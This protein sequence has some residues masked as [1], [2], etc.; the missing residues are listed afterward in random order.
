MRFS[1]DAESEWPDSKGLL[2]GFSCVGVGQVAVLAYY[3]LRRFGMH[4]K[5]IQIRSPPD[6]TLAADLWE[7]VASPESFLMVFGYLTSVWMFGIL[8][9]TYYDTEAPLVWWHVLAQFIVVDIATTLCHLIEHNWPAFY[10]I[11]HK[12]HHRYAES[13]PCQL[14]NS[15]TLSLSNRFTNPKLYIAFNGSPLDTFALIVVPLL[16]TH[17][18]CFF[19]NTNGLA[20]FGTLYAAQFTLIHCE[21][22]HPVSCVPLNTLIM[23]DSPQFSTVGFFV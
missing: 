17:Q 22:R 1:Y 16:I 18:V 20:A 10:K 14:V 8:P 15:H 5:T 6:A 11:S 2:F 19:V 4:S 3:V 21:Y 7:H 9:P 13:T 23:H 12:M